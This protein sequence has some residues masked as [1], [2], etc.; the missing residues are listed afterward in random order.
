MFLVYVYKLWEFE[1]FQPTCL[2]EDLRFCTVAKS[3][4]PDLKY[5]MITGKQDNIKNQTSLLFVDD[6][7]EKGQESSFF[8][9]EYVWFLRVTLQMIGM[10]ECEANVETRVNNI[11]QKWG[12]CHLLGVDTWAFLASPKRL[13]LPIDHLQLWHQEDLIWQDR[14]TLPKRNT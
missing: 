13:P 1:G 8:E 11:F 4:P 10:L 7:G 12:F 5:G 9:Q 6:V 14:L 3:D 2:V